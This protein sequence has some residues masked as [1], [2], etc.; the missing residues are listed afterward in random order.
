MS[1]AHSS[2]EVYAVVPEYVIRAESGVPGGGLACVRVAIYGKRTRNTGP[3]A[4][5]SPG[6]P[7]ARNDHDR[8][9]QMNSFRRSSGA[10]IEMMQSTNL[11]NRDHLAAVQWLNIA[12]NR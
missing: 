1:A 10:A 6:L 11:R 7:Y 12:C 3:P 5:E 4:R 2:F 9:A 8:P